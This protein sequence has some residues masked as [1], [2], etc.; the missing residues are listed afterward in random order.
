MKRLY[1]LIV[2]IALMA[3]AVLEAKH[4]VGGEITYQVVSSTATS[5]R[6]RFTM[7]IYRDC[8]S[9]QSADFDDPAIIGI[10]NANTNML[11]ES[12]IVPKGPKVNVPA[13]TYP[14]LVLP[15]DVCVDEATY[16]WEKTLAIT[17]FS[18]VVLYQRCCRNETIS[19]IINPGNF[20]ATYSVEI[21]SLAQSTQNNS[22]TFKQFPPTVI[23]ANEP[24]RFD[25]SATDAEGD[26][27]V[28]EF[29][30]PLPGGG[31]S[32]S[33]LN[34]C[35]LVQPS[36]PCWPPP[37]SLVFK[38]PD[39]TYDKPVGGDP[40]VKIDPRTGLITGTPREQG[41]FVVGVC[42]KEYRNGRLLTTLQRD[43]QFNVTACDPTVRG[44]I[45]ADTVFGKNYLLRAC[46]DKQIKIN[47]L[48]QDPAVVGNDFA[49]KINIGGQVRTFTDWQPTI[50]F[51]DTGRYTGNL[52]LKPGTQC[53]DTINLI[54]E[55]A[56]G[57]N[58]NFKY[59]Y[60]TCVA[61]AVQF[62]DLSNTAG[63]SVTRWFW[64]FG[65]N[66]VSSQRNPSFQ[67]ETPGFKEVLLRT[68]NSRGCSD[69]SIAT[70]RWQ[71]VAPLLL[72]APSLF[73]GCS[74][75][76]IKF[77]QLSKPV[78]STYKI[79][80]DFGDG[81]KGSAVN[82]SHTY[83]KPG[84]YSIFL[85]VTSPI[86]C[87][88]SR[89]FPDLITIRQGTKANFEFTPK[90]V[91]TFNN[92]VSFFDRSTFASRWQWFFDDDGYSI[93]T[94]PTYRFRDTGV[95]KVKLQV[96]NQYCTD[97]IVKFID[98]IPKVTYFLPNAF[99]P[100]SDGNND[101]YRG[102]GYTDGM[103]EF[104]FRIFNRWGEK[105][106]ET[107]DPAA[108]WNGK[109]FNTGQDEPQGVY[110]CIV[111]YVNPRGENQEIKSYATLVR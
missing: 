38:T 97:T 70:I 10:Y 72:I 81:G 43:F 86:G 99:S 51:P 47:N 74:P 102:L 3:P 12:F 20:G 31:R 50:S 111:T 48:S 89:T 101:S 94:N 46:G 23:C 8:N 6:Y 24:L 1:H 79:E 14:C 93:L 53:S 29:C 66:K 90:E 67:F 61:G 60:D 85:K 44:K 5:N 34:N 27:L 68:F 54:F 88:T 84:T 78:D 106:F 83:D 64:D 40:I 19:N 76:T 7:K 59:T 80:W 39:Y 37:G 22:P 57:V 13:P 35:S 26:Q 42:V 17:N 49:F 16:T 33:G 69:D 96:S 28:Y 45:K 36:P 107:T 58:S 21:T 75:A 2:L 32:N 41:Q 9:V 82:P 30:Q 55:I 110:L 87:S 92:Q 63:A 95:H 73:T 98:V 15:P 108:S 4:I 25:H 77:N 104:K 91:T 71:P 11:I 62:T 52:L 18:Y 100:N 56:P 105:I 103:R 65:D 109:K